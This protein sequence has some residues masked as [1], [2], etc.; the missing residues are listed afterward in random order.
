M[1]KLMD[2]A[3]QKFGRWLVIGR[4]IKPGNRLTF[5]LCE[6][7]CGI[8]KAVAAMCLRDGSSKSC[9]CLEKELTSRRSTTHGLTGTPMY[10]IWRN[11]LNR[12][13][14]PSSSRFKNYGERGIRVCE[15]LRASPVNLI[16]LI[17]DRPFSSSTLGRPNNDGMYSCGD[18][19]E[20]LQKQW[21]LNVGWETVLQQVRNRS[22]TSFATHG[23]VTKPV[24]QWA[25]ETGIKYS[26]LQY[27]RRR[28]LPILTK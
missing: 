15:F 5:W 12:C 6:C 27:R 8:Q 17:G 11:M 25:E 23:G 21:K 18:C 26:T 22:I 13:Y 20:C 10:G 19:A 2:L 14:A 16:A 9:G 1:A 4:V 7:D 28:G 24:A 3:G